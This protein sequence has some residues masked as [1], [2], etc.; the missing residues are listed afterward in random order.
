M[1]CP[2]ALDVI[3][4]NVEIVETVDFQQK[5]NLKKEYPTE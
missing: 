1:L 4:F 2:I 5:N 3:V